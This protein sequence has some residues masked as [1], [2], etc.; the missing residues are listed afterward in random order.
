M[1][2]DKITENL[3][4]LISKNP[5]LHEVLTKLNAN[6]IRYGLY[7]GVHVAILTDN[8]IPT[9]IDLLVYDDDIAKLKTLFP[10]AKVK[11]DGKGCF[12]LH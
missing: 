11:D 6:N 2:D 10:N 9:D 5:D 3:R 8:R 12:S 4:V 1:N 7:A